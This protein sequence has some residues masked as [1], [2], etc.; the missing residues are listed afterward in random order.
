MF[1]AIQMRNKH[2]YP[3]KAEDDII[4]ANHRRVLDFHFDNWMTL[5]KM[6]KY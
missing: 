6:H 3:V 1:K 4:T 2:D 5:G